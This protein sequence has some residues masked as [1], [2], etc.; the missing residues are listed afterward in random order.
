MNI[1][2]SGVGKYH[3]NPKNT[4]LLTLA[5][6]NI[7]TKNEFEEENFYV[8][9]FLFILYYYLPFLDGSKKKHCTIYL[10]LI[11]IVHKLSTST[12]N[13]KTEKNK[14]KC[15]GPTN[16]SMKAPNIFGIFYYRKGV[17]LVKYQI[18]MGIKI[19]AKA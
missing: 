6:V 10:H 13:T 3:T 8:I 9:F 11:V 4:I 1:S 7:F 12:K 17:Y 16:K 19:M 14:T 5:S 18:R 15:E 2:N